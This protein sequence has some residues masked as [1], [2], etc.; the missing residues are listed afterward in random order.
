M[1]RLMMTR[2]WTKNQHNVED[3][4]E[5][6]NLNKEH[7]VFDSFPT[8]WANYVRCFSLLDCIVISQELYLF[9]FFL[10]KRN[11][12]SAK[13]KTKRPCIEGIDEKEIIGYCSSNIL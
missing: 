10:A 6:Y 12:I 8:A 11:C 13:T 9:F 5:V 1:V 4:K 2:G 7:G 3:E